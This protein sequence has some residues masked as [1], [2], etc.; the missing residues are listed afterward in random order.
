MNIR[1]KNLIYE[2][3]RSKSVSYN[4]EIVFMFLILLHFNILGIN[5][6]PV[7]DFTLQMIIYLLC[8]YHT[9]KF[10]IWTK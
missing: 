5:I 10:Y 7:K 3:L 8:F 6:F 9:L 1:T 4:S 2:I